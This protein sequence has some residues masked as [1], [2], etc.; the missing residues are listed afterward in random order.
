[1]FS[2][3]FFLTKKSQQY[4]CI[5]QNATSLTHLY[6]GLYIILNSGETISKIKKNLKF[7]ITLWHI[8]KYLTYI[9]KVSPPLYSWRID[10]CNTS[11]Y[12]KWLMTVERWSV[13][14][15]WMFV[16]NMIGVSEGG[17]RW[18]GDRTNVVGCFHDVDK[19][20]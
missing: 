19:A 12:N 10:A 8:R 17:A 20:R 1:M 5:K 7:P 11:S 3:F 4:T 15:R 14:S 18:R 2:I 6:W 13:I 16:C 9:V